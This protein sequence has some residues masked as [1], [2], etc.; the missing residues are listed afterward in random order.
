MSLI[1]RKLRSWPCLA[2]FF[3]SPV[4]TF[5][6]RRNNSLSGSCM[7]GRDAMALSGA[8]SYYI[9]HRGIPGSVAGSQPGLHG[10]TPPGMRSL[11]NPGAALSVPPSGV[12]PSAFQVESPAAVSSHGGGGLGG[13][14]QMEPVRKK[15]G[16]PRKY[17]PDGNVALALSP[18]SS[19]AP[20]GTAIGSASASGSGAPS[21]KRGR[22]RP[23]GSGRKQQLALLGA[24]KI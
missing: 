2:R 13:V 21:Q 1:T 11:P 12:G 17:G 9:S 15:R 22:G 7:D 23:P 19:S 10:T 24:L 4:T 8:A 20:S 16:R 18:I 3:P 14:S 6:G 5:V